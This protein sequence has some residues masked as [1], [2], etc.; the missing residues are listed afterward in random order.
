[1][2][3]KTSVSPARLDRLKQL[4]NEQRQA[5]ASYAAAEDAIAAAEQGITAAKLRVKEAHEQVEAAYQVLVG[6]M[7]TTVAS[8]LVGRRPSKMRTPSVRRNPAGDGDGAAPEATDPNGELA[9]AV[10]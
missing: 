6:L 4:Y 1:V 2:A 5:L 9:P 10:A 8:E 3:H 7:G